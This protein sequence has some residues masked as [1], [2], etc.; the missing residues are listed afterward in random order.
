[1]ISSVIYLFIFVFIIF[2]ERG[3]KSYKTKNIIELKN[4]YKKCEYRILFFKLDII[5]IIFK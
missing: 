1:M 3:N 4:V 2:K 5:F